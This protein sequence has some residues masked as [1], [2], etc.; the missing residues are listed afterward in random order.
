MLAL[1]PRSTVPATVADRG[2][3]G[4]VETTSKRTLLFK[5]LA[6]EPVVRPGD[7]VVTWRARADTE[8]A[9]GGIAE[10]ASA[11]GGSAETYFVEGFEIGTV[12]AVRGEEA[13]WQTAVLE[14][15]ASLD[16]LSEVLVVV[17]Q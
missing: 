1:D 14:R 6:D 2:V 8:A 17:G 5:Y 16:Q 10:D 12:A 3:R 15:P 4:I 7:R 11:E 9:E 13:G